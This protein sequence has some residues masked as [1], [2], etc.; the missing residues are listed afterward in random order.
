MWFRFPPGWDSINVEQQD[1]PS[2]FKDQ[3]GNNYMVAPEVLADRI[4]VIPGF[5]VVGRPEGAPSTIKDDTPAPSKV[6]PLAQLSSQVETY[7]LENEVLKQGVADLTKER[8]GLKAEIA[9]LH[10]I[11]EREFGEEKAEEVKAEVPSTPT[12]TVGPTGATGPTGDTGGSTGS[13][14]PTGSTG[15]TG[16]TSTSTSGTRK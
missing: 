4:L 5:A 12:A 2:V 14:G 7:R 9:A 3:D 11:I 16:T 10:G 13:T 8:D 15:G 1:F 6:D